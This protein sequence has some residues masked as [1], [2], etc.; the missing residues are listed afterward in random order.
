MDPDHA[1]PTLV[2]NP[3]QAFG[4][5]NLATTLKWNNDGSKDYD[6]T[7]GNNVYAQPDLDGK[8]ATQNNAARSSTALPNLT[9]NF[10][11]DFNIDPLKSTANKNFAITNLFYWNNMMHDMSYQYGFTEAAGNF[12]QNNKEPWWQSLRIM[13]LLMVWMAAAPTMPTLQRL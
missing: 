12:Q 6:S 5:G 10:T 3:W 9:F 11:P 1:A 8:N 13:S 7:R 2:S 4:A